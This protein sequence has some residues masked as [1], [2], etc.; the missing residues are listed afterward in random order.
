M[1]TVAEVGLPP[2]SGL[3][4]ICSGSPRAPP[5]SVEGVVVAVVVDLLL[6]PPAVAFGGFAKVLPRSAVMAVV[7]VVV[8]SDWLRPR[9]DVESGTGSV[10]VEDSVLVHVASG[11][12]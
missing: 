7:K 6:V 3:S 5:A 8:S 1:V 11:C 4:E 2:A 10:V 9:F 12:V